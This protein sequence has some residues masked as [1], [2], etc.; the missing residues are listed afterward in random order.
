[1]NVTPVY[2]RNLPNNYWPISLTTQACKILESFIFNHI[3]ELKT[4]L[5]ANS[6]DLLTIS[7]ASQIYRKLLKTGRLL[8]IYGKALT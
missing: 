6:V 4:S 5:Q 3:I 7:S 1:M 8:L 2:Q